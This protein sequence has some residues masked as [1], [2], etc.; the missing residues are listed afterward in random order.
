[1]EHG[2]EYLL[3]D[4]DKM[5]YFFV[6]K[7]S[8]DDI[9]SK[10]EIG[11]I[12]EYKTVLLDDGVTKNTITDYVELVSMST[13]LVTNAP[14]RWE[15]SLW[16]KSIPLTFVCNVSKKYT[17]ISQATSDELIELGV[18]VNI[19]EIIT[20]PWKHAKVFSKMEHAWNIDKA[21]K[22]YSEA[23]KPKIFYGDL[24]DELKEKTLRA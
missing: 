20:Y 6:S 22:E 23:Y 4:N 5:K 9:V 17:D 24:I 2:C 21:L 13:D 16:L 14:E 7:E 10:L 11:N 3:A 19:A 12:Y 15:M 1:I 8:K 18:P